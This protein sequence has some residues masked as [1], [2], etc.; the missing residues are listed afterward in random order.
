MRVCI[1]A[2]ADRRFLSKVIKRLALELPGIP[3]PLLARR[4][5]SFSQAQCRVADG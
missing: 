1:R 2:Q 5:A 4:E 3:I